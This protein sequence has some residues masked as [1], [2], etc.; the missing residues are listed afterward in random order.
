MNEIQETI[1]KIFREIKKVCDDNGI[2]YYAIGGTCI[3]AVRHK[4]FIPWDDDMDIAISIEQFEN[5]Q[6]LAKKRLPDYLRVITCDDVVHTGN[7]FI[8]VHDVRTTFIEKTEYKYPD[9]YKGIFVDVMPLS[10]VPSRLLERTLFSMKIKLY[11][12]LN[13][14][15]RYP[16]EEMHHPIKKIVWKIMHR[17]KKRIT[18]NYYSNKWLKLLEKYPFRK[19]IFT[20][21]VWHDSLKHLVFPTESF[22]I[23]E[24]VQFED[25]KI[26]CPSDW[27]KYL[28]IQFGDYMKLPSKENRK[29]EHDGII[30]V[31]KEYQYFVRHSNIS[32]A[33]EGK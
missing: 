9:A 2:G 20:G 27:N 24:N 22:G 16:Y 33:E 21:Y 29:T 18:V 32:I 14:I 25:T 7:I 13:I 6:I 4:G 23:G 8:K 28:T 15:R 17:F 26:C 10:G 3:G 5:F 1:L 12:R 11:R 31:R 30:K 19:S